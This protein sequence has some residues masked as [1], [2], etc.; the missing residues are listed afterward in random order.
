[1]LPRARLSRP[2]RLCDGKDPNLEDILPTELK[3]R[4]LEAELDRLD[5]DLQWLNQRRQEILE[6][7]RHHEALLS[8]A[9]PHRILPRVK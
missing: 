7:M 6:E 3:L 5:S 2:D 8:K 4:L 9:R 1:M